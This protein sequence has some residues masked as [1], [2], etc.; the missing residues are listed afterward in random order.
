M[1]STILLIIKILS[2]YINPFKD[3]IY[4]FNVRLKYL[5]SINHKIR[6]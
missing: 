6:Y 5:T 4:L 3:K 1:Y 2:I